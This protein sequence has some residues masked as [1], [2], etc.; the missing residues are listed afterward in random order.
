MAETNKQKLEKLINKKTQLQI[1]LTKIATEKE[2]FGK[3][4]DG[5]LSTFHSMRNPRHNRHRDILGRQINN[6]KNQIESYERK[7]QELKVK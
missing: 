2:I 3:S 7:I 6:L 4:N 5:T 1:K